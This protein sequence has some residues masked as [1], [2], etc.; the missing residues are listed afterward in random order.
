MVLLSRTEPPCSRIE[1]SIL[2]VCLLFIGLVPNG[3]LGGM[4]WQQ[5]TCSA[6]PAVHCDPHC[7][8][9]D[10]VACKY[11]DS[12]GTAVRVTLNSAGVRKER[13]QV[14]PPFFGSKVRASYLSRLE[15]SPELPVHRAARF[16]LPPKK[17]AK[18]KR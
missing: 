14:F 8:L 1:Q 12:D 6:G 3:W 18:P 2:L 5:E 7:N 17:H 13:K 9:W 15:T 11:S 16:P 10:G 4:R